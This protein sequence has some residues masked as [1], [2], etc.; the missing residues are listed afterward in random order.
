MKPVFEWDNEKAVSNFRKHRVSFNEATTIFLDP[1]SIT[2]VDPQHSEN[3]LRYVDIGLSE[4]GRLL[5][6][7]Y[8]ER[9]EKIR[10]ISCRL[11]T[12]MERKLYEEGIS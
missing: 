8:T 11:A 2:I 12:Q 1:F 5:L 10:L 4:Q 6:V 9:N 3:E 7:V